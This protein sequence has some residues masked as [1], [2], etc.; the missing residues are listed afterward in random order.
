MDKERKK[1]RE[2]L[3]SVIDVVKASKQKIFLFVAIVKA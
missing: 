1:W 2:I 3:Q